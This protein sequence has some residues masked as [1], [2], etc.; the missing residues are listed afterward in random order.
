MNLSKSRYT[1]GITCGKKLWL[2]CYKPEEAQE[3]DNDAVLDNGT[4]VGELARGLFGNY[5]LVEYD[6][7]YKNM[8]DKTSELLL[9]KPN[10]ICEA[11]F[12]YDGNFC[13]VDILKND[14]DGV[15]IYEVKSSTDINSIYIDDISYQTWVLKKCGLNVKKSCIVYI[16]GQ[17]IKNGELD[18]NELFNIKD[19]TADL[20]LDSVEENV[21]DLKKV[22][23]RKEEPSIDLSKACKKPY[24]CPFFE[25]CTRNLPSP[26]VFD[27][28]W[29][30]HFSKKLEM[31]KRG[32]I[33]FDDVI[34]K[35]IL[36]DKATVQ[37]RTYVKD[38]PPIIDKEA[39]KE[40]MSKLRYPLYFLDFESYQDAIPR[41]DGTKTYQQICFQYSLHYYLEEGGELLHKEYLSS[42]YDGN[43]MYGLC[44]QLCEDIPMDSCVTAYNKAF[45]CTRLKEMARMFPE[46]SEHLLNISD[47]IIDLEVPF[48]NQDY[49]VKDMAGRSSIK[50]VL[51][52]LFP[53]DP[54]LDY[55]NLEQV[56]KG[57]EASN[58]YLS[59]P[60]L[61]K[62][63]E[64]TLRTNMLKYCALDTYAMVKIYEA[65]Q[66][67]I[68]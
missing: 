33:T 26:N 48:A 22:I 49:Y 4:M 42:D 64:E 34:D 35:E 32:H 39:I 50:V 68:K 51:P 43:P 56:H 41:I 14:I 61:S 31:Y 6:T 12:S 66:D 28:G 11:S 45:E 46:F 20:D 63:E 18:I 38:D 8:L 59:L 40:L 13:S 25:Y 30:M 10:I 15:E 29:S 37:V 53:D 2:S 52:A 36:N 5:E 62:E 57:D 9:N 55:H 7:N 47:N 21:K 16:N 60:S 23:N 67:A 17:Y 44:K 54:N 58:A 65:L 27:I 19:V 3:E 1:T 24:D